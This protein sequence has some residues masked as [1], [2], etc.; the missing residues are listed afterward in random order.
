MPAATACRRE[1]SPSQFERFILREER[2]VAENLV[3]V[4][5]FDVGVVAKDLLAGLACGEQTEQ[6]CNR[7][8]EPADARFAG[9]DG[10]INGDA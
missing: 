10:R 8:P 2:G 1:I 7:E 5:R 3:D 9:T 6:P 4:A